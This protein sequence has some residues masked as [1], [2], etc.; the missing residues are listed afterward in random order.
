MLLVSLIPSVLA[1]SDGFWCRINR[2]STPVSKLRKPR[3]S[4]SAAV[5]DSEW[6]SPG[7]KYSVCDMC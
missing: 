6:I 3:T 5:S 4:T 7:V 1:R 2:N